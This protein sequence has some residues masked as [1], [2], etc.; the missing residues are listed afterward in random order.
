M[1]LTEHMRS[2]QMDQIPT[3]LPAPVG[4]HNLR[5][6]QTLATERNLT[7]ANLLLSPPAEALLD[8]AQLENYLNLQLVPWRQQN[9]TT[10]IA[11]VEFTDKHHQWAQENYADYQFVQTAPLDIHRSLSRTFPKELSRR[12]I[13]HL[14]LTTPIQSART[15]LHQ[16]QHIPLLLLLGFSTL[17]LLMAPASFLALFLLLMGI[18]HALT[19]SLKGI[20]FWR[21]QHYR[22]HL[23]QM[24]QYKPDIPESALPTYTLLIPLY[25]EARS[26]P[27]LIA[28]L[29]KIDYPHHKLDIKLIIEEDDNETY[30]TAKQL[31]PAP[32][33]EILRVPHSLPKTKPKACNYAL[34]FARGE[35]ITIYDA[36]DRPHPKQLKQVAKQFY[37]STKDLVCVQCRL[38]YYNRPHNLLTRLFSIEYAAWFDFMIPGLESLRLPIPLGGT[39]NHISRQK[40]LELGEWDPFNV[41]E[42]ADLGIRLASFRYRTEIIRS[43]TLEEAPIQLW[44]WMKQRSRWI[45]GY[46]Q[47]WLV[48][49]RR[50]IWLWHKLGLRGFL[51]FQLFIGGPCLV[52]LSTPI[53]LA[54][55]VYWAFYP[56]LWNHP[57]APLILPLSLSCLCFGIILHG[58][59]AWKTVRFRN[60]PQMKL[61]ITC[62]PFYWLLHSVA[63]FRAFWQLL[64]RPHY[65]EKTEHGLS[66]APVSAAIT[67]PRPHPKTVPQG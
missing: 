30:E 3:P 10:L 52:F 17:Q 5:L 42:D 12:S 28:A 58:F 35:M 59:F 19:L 15:L 55:S 25:K 45:K 33:F 49:M 24:H 40:L 20:L 51:G 46:M 21:G 67:P 65:W 22:Q 8:A 54:C 23:W 37:Y 60:W 64:T 1:T 50:P 47:T 44:P 62:F 13:H 66:G 41:T 43:Q 7:F 26:L 53:L 31:R 32:H 27:H 11:G 16:S 61:A 57:A 6:Y 2:E 34:R 63:S 14:A 48:H 9:D 39:S 29:N 36:E 4:S 18:F 56:P 38:N